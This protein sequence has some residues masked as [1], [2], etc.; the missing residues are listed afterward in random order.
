MIRVSIPQIR[1]AE[2]FDAYPNRAAT[3]HAIADFDRILAMPKTFEQSLDEIARLTQF[4]RT[5]HAAFLSP[6]TLEADARQSL[7]DPFFV[8]LDWDVHNTEGAMLKY[9]PVLFEESR[10]IQG[11]RKAPD[12]T[13]R[14]GGESKFFAEAKKPRVSI[15]NDRDPAYQLRRYGWSANL[16][17]SLLTDFEELAVYDC[18]ITPKA[19]DTARTARLKFYTFEQ[20]PDQWRELW[21]LFSFSA[22]RGGSF[23]QFVETRLSKRGVIPVDAQILNDIQAWRVLLARNIA[24][25]NPSLSA[26]DLNDAV[27]KT[28]DRILFLRIA[29]DRG[30]EPYERML[31]ATR[32]DAIYPELVRL[33]RLADQKYNSGLFDF[34]RTGDKLTPTLTIDDAVLKEI[35]SQLYVP[36]SPYEFKVIPVEILGNVYEQF[37]GQVIHLTPAHQARVQDK[38]EVRKAGGVYYTP[39]YIVKYIVEQTVGRAVQAKSPRELKNFRVLDMACG[40]GS[41]LL[42]AYQY[43]LDWYLKWYVEHEPGKFK[44]A[45]QNIQGEWRLTTA[46]RKRILTT[47][48]FGVDIDRQAVEVSKLSLLL[49]VLEGESQE[50]LQPVLEGLRERALPNLDANIKCGNS[51]IAPDYFTGQM[52]PDAEE[53]KRVNPFDWSREFPEAMRDGGFDCVIGNPPYIRIQ[54]MK[55]W[56]PL[57]VEIYKQLYASAGTGNYDIYV[58]FVEKGLHLLN[59]RGRLGFILPHKFFN[60]QYGAPLRNL[61]ANG[62]HLNHVVHFGDE[63]VFSGATTYTCLLFADQAPNPQVDFARVDDLEKWRT[64]SEATRGVVPAEKV[65]AV[66]WNFV[67]GAGASLFTKLNALPLKLQNVTD[68]IFQGLKT[69][70]DKIYIVK[71]LERQADRVKIF[72]HEKNAEYWLESNLLHPLIKGG[73]SK[74]YYLARTTRLILFPYEPQG[75]IYGLISEPSFKQE[76]PLT[77]AY[78]LAN[79]NYL[80]NREDGKMRGRHWYA[81]GRTQA[82]D[83]MSLPKIF[84]PDI[85]ARS[86][87]SFDDTGVV[88]FTGGVAGGYGILVSKE[89]SRFFVLGLLNSRLL[90]WFIRQTATQMR[91]GYYSY[92]SRFIR[93]LPI[94]PINF[95]DPADVARRDKIVLLVEQMLALQQQLHDAH[96]DAQRAVLQRQ[97][98]ST[99][100]QIDALVYEL[101]DLTPDEIEI[102]EGKASARTPNAP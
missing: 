29:E 78:L 92:E 39:A 100:A 81:Y 76:Y 2:N 17:L 42:G 30:I 72:S 3:L 55:E 88:F 84:T 77:W 32:R 87:F 74:R 25:R 31:K 73:D 86:S 97:V 61:I 93:N 65:T 27:Q 22:V 59:A 53:L 91:G 4:Y 56:A 38:P 19:T 79:K 13:F 9:R 95:S 47:H 40:S 99:D 33:F 37:L 82:L 12:Y 20:Y 43:L 45:V 10:E 21:D 11:T 44:N 6:N 51:L 5:N 35:I 16:P 80:E 62:K 28:L 63:Q 52:F 75:N 89:Y 69:S 90:E 98:E 102:V 46:E 85:A 67:V 57:E 8:A 18:R 26:D 68:R 1:V 60:A 34:S 54:T 14:V 50:T 41:F 58:V 66:E 64:S 101:Y 71:E 49:Q 36:Q 70:A 15:E 83:V 24:R 94:R 7:I 96:S 23:D 48:I